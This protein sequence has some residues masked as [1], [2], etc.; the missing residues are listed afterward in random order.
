VAL[1]ASDLSCIAAQQHRPCRTHPRI[2]R[3]LLLGV[4]PLEGT[5]VTRHLHVLVDV[6]HDALGLKHLR[7]DV[8]Q[9]CEAPPR[10]PSNGTGLDQGSWCQPCQEHDAANSDVFRCS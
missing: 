8:K 7:K 9:G 10:Q 3:H 1:Q 6:L 2:Y 5:E 4:V